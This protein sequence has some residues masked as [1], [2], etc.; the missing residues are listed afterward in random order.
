MLLRLAIGLAFIV[1]PMLE[2]LLLIKIGQTIGVWLTV[3]LVLGTALTGAYIISRQSVS[4]LS[5]TLEALGEGRVPVEPVLD[6]LFLMVAGVLLLTPGLATD[7][8]ALA[9]LIPPL[10]RSVARATMRWLLARSGIRTKAHGRARGHA[11]ARRS[12]AERWPPRSDA[13]A[14]GPIIDVEAE[15]VDE[16]P[17]KPRRDGGRG[18]DL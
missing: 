18:P 15:R 8:V 5:R 16:E 12:G 1:V 2:L 14:S 10:R 11:G 4:V 9:L 13:A 6:G 3:A 17:A 7:V